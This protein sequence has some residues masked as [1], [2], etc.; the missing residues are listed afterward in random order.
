M[1]YVLNKSRICSIWWKIDP[2]WSKISKSGI[3]V[4]GGVTNLGRLAPTW[5]NTEIL[6]YTSV[7]FGS[8]MC[9]FDANFASLNCAKTMV[10]F[11]YSGDV[12]LDKSWAFLVF[13]NTEPKSTHGRTC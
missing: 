5:G 12:E 1:K 10:V 13:Y 3:P 6:C 4:P 2:L 11:L 7:H 9:I 8:E